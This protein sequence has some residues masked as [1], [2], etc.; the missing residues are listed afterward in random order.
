MQGNAIPERRALPK[1]VLLI[2]DEADIA[3]AMAAF[4]GSYGV[5]LLA[6]PNEH[7]ATAAF[8]Q[9]AAQGAPFEALICDYRL[10]DGANGL[11]IGL[12]LR[13]RFAPKLPL[14]LATGETVPDRLQRVQDS[15]VPV[16]F[17][18][19]AAEILLK[20]LTTLRRTI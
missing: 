18:P 20:T 19:V 14:L 9:A 13:R 6:V 3:E 10:A 11:D 16:L 8:S 1:Q 2:D 7:E 12:R 4:L 17:K 5:T 15:S